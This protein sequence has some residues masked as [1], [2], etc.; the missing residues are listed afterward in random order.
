MLCA[1][2][3]SRVSG[4]DASVKRDNLKYRFEGEGS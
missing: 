1:I 4:L 3:V 2:V